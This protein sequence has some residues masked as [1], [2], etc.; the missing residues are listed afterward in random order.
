M[1]NEKALRLTLVPAL[2]LGC[3]AYVFPGKAYR[4]TAYTTDIVF[5]SP[6]HFY[7]DFWSVS[8]SIIVRDYTYLTYRVRNGMKTVEC[9][10][11]EGGPYETLFTATKGGEH[12][13]LD[14]ESQCGAFSGEGN[15]YVI[16]FV[17]HF[18]MAGS[19]FSLQFH[20]EKEDGGGLVYHTKTSPYLFPSGGEYHPHR[21][22]YDF[23][24]ATLPNAN[25][26][27]DYYYRA[28]PFKSAGNQVL[29]PFNITLQKI[30]TETETATECAASNA[31]LRI[32]SHLWEFQQSADRINVN[33]G[34]VEFDLVSNYSQGYLSF[35]LKRS[36]YVDVG[37]GKMKARQENPLRD[38]KTNCVLLPMEG[39]ESS[40]VYDCEL[41]FML[42]NDYFMMKTSQIN[43][44]N[45][46]GGKGNRYHVEIGGYR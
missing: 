20:T 28:S 10:E 3:S 27:Y 8:D 26:S 14:L 33:T 13:K 12:F 37:T 16:D 11:H 25:Y 1:V 35:A 44:H 7:F 24:R 45:G 18:E 6:F 15:T 30:R 31:V 38:A 36:R 2:G 4:Y 39:K 34:D 23:A 32:K 42:D 21:T 9:E 41:T 22:S 40:A 19:G 43:L 46:V 5:R 29:T 17:A